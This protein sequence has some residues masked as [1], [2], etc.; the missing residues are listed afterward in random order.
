ME[1]HPPDHSI[2]NWRDVLVHLGIM[3]LGLFIALSLESLVELGHRHHLA[4][5]TRASLQEEFKRNRE[6][7]ETDVRAYRLLRSAMQQNV[8]ILQAL[9]AKPHSTEAELP[10]K[11][12]WLAGWEPLS[13]TE[14]HT[15]NQTT[16]LSLLEHHEV[17]RYSESYAEA[18]EINKAWDIAGHHIYR[19]GGYTH[20]DPD[21]TH[22]S[23]EQIDE[24]LAGCGVILSEL[25]VVGF[26]LVN[27]AE[28]NQVAEFSL[29]KDEVIREH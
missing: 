5:E 9:K 14:W 8:R 15:A 19:V 1:V 4:N 17:A 13:E 28:S 26:E 6:Y 20:V 10:G 27:W 21:A 25:Q 3:T 22:L 18:E 16:G 12:F 11:L 2:H 29:Q 24:L 23:P 7:L